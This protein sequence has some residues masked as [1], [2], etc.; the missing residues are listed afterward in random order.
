MN[1]SSGKSG[2][3]SAQSL[4]AKLGLATTWPRFVSFASLRFVYFASFPPLN[5]H[6]DE[7]VSSNTT[8]LVELAEAFIKQGRPIELFFAFDVVVPVLFLVAMTK[9]GLFGLS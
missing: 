6:L 4:Q 3:A 2:I 7:I 5:M 1:I 9:Q 8:P